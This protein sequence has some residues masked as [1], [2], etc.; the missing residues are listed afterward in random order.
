DDD[1]DD[2][3]NNDDSDKN[4]NRSNNDNGDGGNADNDSNDNG[5]D[6]DDDDD[7]D[8]DNDDVEE[9]DLDEDF[10]MN[11][12]DKEKEMT[13]LMIKSMP[14][15]S[16]TNA[17]ERQQVYASMDIKP[18]AATR[19]K[20]RNKAS[21]S[22]H[23]RPRAHSPPIYAPQLNQFTSDTFTYIAAANETL[24]APA[25]IRKKN[26]S[27]N[28]TDNDNSRRYVDGDDEEDEE[29]EEEKNND[30]GQK[31][32]ANAMFGHSMKSHPLHKFG[33]RVKSSNAIYDTPSN[34]D[35]ITNDTS[36]LLDSSYQSNALQIT[37]DTESQLIKLRKIKV[38]S[39][40]GAPL[41]KTPSGANSNTSTSE[42]TWKTMKSADDYIIVQDHSK[43]KLKHHSEPGNNKPSDKTVVDEEE[44]K[45]Q[46]Q[47]SRSGSRGGSQVNSPNLDLMQQTSN[48]NPKHMI[49]QV[50]PFD[51]ESIS[52]LLRQTTYSDNGAIHAKNLMNDGK[53]KNI[54]HE[55]HTE[56]NV[57]NATSPT[58]DNIHL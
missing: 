19:R 21:E 35:P 29:E 15:I 47:K 36:S 24:S 20:L 25:S 49:E 32:H 3:N 56:Q 16:E 4:K 10:E 27:D 57:R 2:D 54:K 13:E 45:E 48:V 34:E 7:N 39:Q 58:N 6:D 33:M 12:N 17:M 38:S 46:G 52:E 18:P 1:D 26:F 8:N 43:N 30:G 11:H 14:I 5:D 41:S 53:E 40:K 44:T 50:F 31:V 37:K 28:D 22:P 9:D 42:M 23:I 51:E 55:E